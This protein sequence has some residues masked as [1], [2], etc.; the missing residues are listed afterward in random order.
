MKKYR[1]K[2]FI[3]SFTAHFLLIFSIGL[4]LLGSLGFK[5]DGPT[6]SS[7]L[8]VENVNA[9]IDGGPLQ[10]ITLPHTFHNLSPGTPV[11]ITTSIQPEFY[12]GVYIKTVYS[13]AK[14]FLDGKLVFEF[15][16]EENH[17][18]F[19]TDP[20]PEIHIVE[21]YGNGEDMMLQVDFLSP[22]T[23]NYLFVDRFLVGTSKEIILE[24]SEQSGLPMIFSLVQIIGGISLLLISFC[25]TLIDPKGVLFLWLG[26]FSLTTGIWAFGRN[27]F[28]VTIF[29]SSTMLYLFS[30]IGMFS[31]IVPLLHFIR[32][33]VDFKNQK[34]IWG[35]EACF[36]FLAGTALILQLVGLIPCNQSMYLFRFALPPTL[37]WM[38]ALTIREFRLYHSN[39][40]KWFIFPLAILA[41]CSVLDLIGL[42]SPFPTIFSSLLQMGILIF[43]LLVGV[44]SG[45]KVKDSIDLQKR[46]RELVYEKKLLDIQT[47]EQRKES[48][49]LAKN[50]QELS[51]QRHDLRH[52]LTV[53]Q[54]LAGNNTELQDYLSTI[55]GKIPK[56]KE[57]FCENTIV[58]AVVSHYASL[59]EK[60]GIEF[61]FKLVVPET[62]SQ[63][64]DSN[65]CV[66]FSNLL[67][68]AIEAC[69]RMDS[70]KQ[71]I[72]LNSTLHGKLFT[73]TLDNSFNSIV[74]QESERFLSSKRAG[75]GIGLASIRS[76]VEKAQGNADFHAEGNVFLS[77]LYMIL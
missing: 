11:T 61:I 33:I 8:H 62:G 40:A 53:I 26:L 27:N 10:K 66:I 76:I 58:N 45:M 37:V 60:K 56:S 16:K 72:H 31:F 44:I 38:T 34:F 3:L 48:M 75:F 6:S 41:L 21:S 55:V 74:K 9:S 43:L 24:R 47:Q 70:G 57:H 52:H 49:L 15:G 2:N 22:Q 12:D 64:V 23:R 5:R 67:E 14:V 36:S 71:F 42:R 20:A 25:I 17:P 29:R 19:M 13:P 51:R 54:E 7:V 30:F 28:S 50:E 35:I 1:D 4:L 65:L 63:I 69:E 68:N 39:N 77:S 46:E 73:V 32:T 59:C 18:A